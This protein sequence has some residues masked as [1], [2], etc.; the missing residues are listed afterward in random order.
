MIILI[1]YIGI[2]KARFVNSLNI[3]DTTISPTVEPT[4]E[5]VS[6]TINDTI[7]QKSSRDISKR[8]KATMT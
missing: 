8:Y 6:P 4:K 5:P 2:Y 1:S 7:T 3:V